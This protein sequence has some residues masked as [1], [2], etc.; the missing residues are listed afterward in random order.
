VLNNS[1]GEIRRR[2]LIVVSAF[3]PA[4][5]A[6]M[7]RA[8]MLAWELPKLGWAVEVL[9]PRAS[10]V[11]QDV[12]EDGA[13]TFFA[14]DV[15]LH[16]VGSVGRRLL[17]ALG[18]RTHVWRTLLP[19]RR[20]GSELISSKRFD[21]IYFSTTAF[22][23]FALGSLWK[24]RYKIP[25]VIDFHDLWV[26]V[27]V[28]AHE[29]DRSWRALLHWGSVP[30]ERYAVV[31]ADG[32]VAVSPHYISILKERYKANNPAWL[33]TGRHAVIPFGA[34]ERDLIEA[35]KASKYVRK[36]KTKELAI[37]YVGAGGSIMARSFA[38]VCRALAA[39]RSQENVAANRVRLHL[40]GTIYNWK[41]GERKPLESIAKEIG[42]GDLVAEFPERVSYRQSLEL[43]LQSDGALILGVDD[44]GY[45]PSKLFSY[46]L[47]GKPLLASLRRDGPAFAQFQC[48][49]QLGHALW[50][51]QYDEM[52]VTESLNVLSDFLQEVVAQRSLDRRTI[53]EPFLAAA[54]A[55]RHVKLFDACL[56]SRVQ[57]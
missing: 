53:L 8:R 45:M 40:Y 7:Q 46:G 38:L 36:H 51:G 22:T 20:R 35:A 41:S 56:S 31:N 25:Y 32:L 19:M 57:S 13:A 3:D 48:N 11:R 27:S 34:L 49:P 54:M 4:I 44:A 43:L 26:K 23:Y 24:R 29:S 50:F 12:I 52:P 55:S 9:T 5:V 28:G 15:P 42:V 17:E 16:E 18:S 6:D 2:V 33:E 1:N 47:S 21:L 37:C 39:L 10:E 30:T 14:P